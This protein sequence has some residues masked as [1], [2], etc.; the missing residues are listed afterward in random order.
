[1]GKLVLKWELGTR[2]RRWDDNI[3]MNNREIY[4]KGER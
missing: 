3:K 4:W 2:I 1:M